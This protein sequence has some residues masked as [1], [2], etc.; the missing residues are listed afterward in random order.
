MP[1]SELGLWLGGLTTADEWRKPSWFK[2]FGTTPEGLEELIDAVGTALDGELLT[3]EELARRP[4]ARSGDEGLAEKLG[5][6]WGAYL[7]PAAFRGLLC[8]APDSGRNVRFTSPGSWLGGV[9][10]VDQDEAL[11]EVARRWLA[12]LGPAERTDLSRWWGWITDARAGK[13]L[14]SLGDE[15]VEADVEGSKLWVL[16]SHAKEIAAAAPSRAVRLV[17]A[18]DQYVVGVPRKGPGAPFEARRRAQIYRQAGWLSPAL[19]VDGRI[20]GVWRHERKGKRL[21]VEIAPFGKPPK[22]VRAGVEEEARRLADFLGGDL[23][24]GWG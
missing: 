24:L 13:L 18:F 16:A 11:R 15:V 14:A 17:P 1:A 10:P 21:A 8:F 7:K 20:D 3:R 12:A 5:E 4:P 23:A 19:V 9:E 6:S 22:W 2:A